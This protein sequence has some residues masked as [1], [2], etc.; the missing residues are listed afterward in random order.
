MIKDG[1]KLHEVIFS[2]KSDPVKEKWIGKRMSK[3]EIESISAIGNVMEIS[4]F[5][6]YIHDMFKSDEIQFIYLDFKRNSYNEV[7]DW[8][9]RLSNS[10]KKKYPFLMIQDFSKDLGE[11]RMI[12]TPI[13]I[14]KMKRAIEI[15][16]NGIYN[17]ITNGKTGMMEY[18][19]EAY[20][21]FILKTNGVSSS[22]HSIIA[23]GINGTTL[24]YEKN[25]CRIDKNSLVLVDVGAQVDYYCADISRTFPIDGK[26]TPRQKEVYAIV[27][28][29]MEQVISSAKPG[30]TLSQL[31]DIAKKF[32]AEGCKKMGIIKEDRELIKYYY[33]GV[34]HF[35]GL[36]PHDVGDR[37]IPLEPGMVITVEPG[38]YIAEV[39]IGI[40]IEDDI[41][42]VEGGNENLSKG[43]IKEIDEIEEF[44]SKRSMV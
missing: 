36:D 25:N 1:N 15:T 27:L 18:E 39:G 34:S 9:E 2:E 21:D 38:L 13:E 17:L 24:H 44:M 16:K 3:D 33:H 4:E 30:I 40:R 10:I 37:S 19:L 32:L 20:F 12:K 28:N 43:I 41:L 8:A 26:F 7:E 6:N 14:D 29:A 42:I 35:L 11:L 22:F 31:N 5:E 23:S